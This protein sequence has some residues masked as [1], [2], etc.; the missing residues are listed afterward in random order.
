MTQTQYRFG[1]CLAIGL[2]LLILLLFAAEIIPQQTKQSSLGPFWFHQGGDDRGYYQQMELL[3][4]GEFEANKY[5]LGFPLL[6]LPF[7]WAIQP[8]DYDHLLQPIALFWSA[9]MLPLGLLLLADMAKR[10]T[11]SRRTA[12][13]ATFLWAG[14]PLLAL[15]FFNLV[16]NAQMAEIIAIHMTW[17][18]MLSDGPTAFFT[19]LAAWCYVRSQ[20][21]GFKPRDAVVLGALLGFVGMLRFTGLLIAFVIGGLLLLQR[22]WRLILIMGVA[23]LLCFAPQMIYNLSFFGSPFSTGYTALDLLPAGGLFNLS[24]LLAALSEIWARLGILSLIA[25]GGGLAILGAA[26]W[27]LW[28][29][30]WVY[31]LLIGGWVLSY[32]GVYSLYYYSWHGALMRFMIPTLPAW[33]LLAAV[34]LGWGIDWVQDVRQTEKQ[35]D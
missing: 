8:P 22:Q 6:M 26:L 18:Q 35:P 17:A 12:L 32:A 20:Q 15:L 11:G 9:V 21:R 19:L 30:R 27:R 29:R 25:V 2:H 4:S 31:A 33:A 3:R 10:I 24:Y 13:L 14:L 34:L 16:W 1:V 23:A 5:P 28:Q 7:S